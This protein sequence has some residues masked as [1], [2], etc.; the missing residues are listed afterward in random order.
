MCFVKYITVAFSVGLPV[1]INNPAPF[2][3][4]RC[5]QFRVIERFCVESSNTRSDRGKL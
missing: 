4:V 1:E 5:Q 3:Q 2:S